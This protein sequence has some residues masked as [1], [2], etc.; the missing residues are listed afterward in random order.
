MKPRVFLAL[1]FVT[2]VLLSACGGSAV[3]TESPATTQ[4][5][6]APGNP[7]AAAEQPSAPSNPY[8]PAEAQK[9]APGA[10]ALYPDA[11]DGQAISWAAVIAMTM[12]AEVK[13]IIVDANLNLTLMLKDGRSLT[14]TAPH[15][16]EVDK[17]VAACGDVCKDLKLTK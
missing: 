8:P 9:P 10:A 12:N 14:S 11:A 3:T 17:L 13:E 2:A 7:T 15:L 16:D 5:A 1:L 4:E 6:A